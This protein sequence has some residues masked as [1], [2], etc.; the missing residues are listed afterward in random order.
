MKR[1]REYSIR[2]KYEADDY[3]KFTS[4]SLSELTFYDD[5]PFVYLTLERPDGSV[6]EDLLFYSIP[7]PSPDDEPPFLRYVESP[8]RLYLPGSSEVNSALSRFVRSEY[9]LGLTPLDIK[10][11]GQEQ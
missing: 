3:P 5:P 1:A 7:F 9:A 2:F 6:I 4:F 10:N 11:S 8:L